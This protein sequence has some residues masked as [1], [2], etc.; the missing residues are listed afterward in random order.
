MRTWSF[1]WSLIRFRPGA[2]ALYTVSSLIF[3][4]GMTVP[5]LLEKAIFDRLT[6]E[7]AAGLTIWALIA[8]YVS[9]ELGR[10]V[11]SY[12]SLLGM[13]NHWFMGSTLLRRNALLGILRRPGAVPLPVS[14]GDA[15]NRFDH[16]VGEVADFPAWLPDVAGHILFAVVAFVI[17][18]Q[19]DA[20]VT[21]VAF[22]PL[23]VVAIITRLAWNRMLR[24]RDASRS[25]TG[26]LTGFLGELFGAVQ[27][28][29]VA[30]GEEGVMA[31]FARLNEVRRKLMVRTHLVTQVVEATFSH[32]VDIGVGVTLLLIGQKMRG[33]SF[34]V[35][36]FAI[37]L[38]YLAFASKVPA[39]IGS[40]LGDYKTQEISINRL[41][42]LLHGEPAGRLVEHGPIYER[43]D[44]PPVLFPPKTAADRLE[45]LE[46]SRLS[47]HYPESNGQRR[48]INN[49]S[50]TLRRASVTVVTGR[51][52]SGK[53]TLLRVLLGLLPRD[54]GQIRWNGELVDEPATFFVPPRAAYTAQTPRLFSE[55]VR[56]NILM[57]LPEDRVDLPGAIRQAVLEPDVAAMA[58][59]L[60]TVVG[61]R[62]V[63]LSGGQAQRAAAA[64]MFVRQPELLVF[65][66]LSSAL[67]VETEQTLWQRLLGVPTRN[68]D[69]SERP[70]CLVV[71]HRRAAL[72][73]ADQIII[74]KDGR[75]EAQGTLDE[76][77]ATNEEMRRLWHGEE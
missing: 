52:G 47:Y 43:G 30:N 38:Y 58:G 23:L 51:V 69:A 2:F 53:T 37:F 45:R 17:L 71:S 64:R 65:D 62:G 9:F 50:L 26:A 6:G 76:L 48:G 27:A 35:G 42:E 7:A 72:S 13:T 70:T 41:G 8:L 21:V 59:G 20:L 14:A 74:L 68:G 5:G 3:F 39:V 63:R 1:V 66:D 12:L 10:L 28:V 33:G 11:T 16:D 19:I 18:A 36:D 46:V 40:F 61:P 44:L 56:D 55:T 57:G 32:T 67:D 60:E 25:A 15:L 31:H 22:V 34:T 24:L 54:G 49:I 4:L 73:Q 29:K 75:V 77:L